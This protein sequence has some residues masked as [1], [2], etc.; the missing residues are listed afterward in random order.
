MNKDR[1]HEAHM[2]MDDL[3]LTDRDTVQQINS[4]LDQMDEWF[5]ALTPDLKWFEQQTAEAKRRQ[6]QKLMLEL[7]VF[8][9]VAVMVISVSYLIVMQQPFV[10]FIVQLIV[11]AAMPVAFVL[12]RS[13]K[14]ERR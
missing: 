1:E 4:G 6:K 8:W 7:V 5:P 11:A 10:Y 2:G 14:A 3:H 12:N 13:R 9:M